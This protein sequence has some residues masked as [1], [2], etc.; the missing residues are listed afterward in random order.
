MPIEGGPAPCASHSCSR[1][2]IAGAPGDPA[3]NGLDGESCTVTDGN[4]TFTMTCPDGSTETWSEAIVAQVAVTVTLVT[5]GTGGTILTN[6]D[7]V[8]WT[9]QPSNSISDLYGWLGVAKGHRAVREGGQA[10]MGRS[11]GPTL[12]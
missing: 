9:T 8:T 4:G 1:F 3:T 10:G 7:G 2:V 11:P 6:P 12:I 5:V